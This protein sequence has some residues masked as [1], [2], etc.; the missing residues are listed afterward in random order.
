MYPTNA[1]LAAMALATAGCGQPKSN[2]GQPLARIGDQTITWTDLNKAYKDLNKDADVDLDAQL[3]QLELQHQAQVYQ[4]KRQAL[5]GLIQKRV[6]DAKAK[7]AGMGSGDELMQK[8]QQE[9]AAKIPD[10]PDAELQAVYDQAKA[11]GQQL[12]PFDQV[13]PDIIRFVKQQKMRGELVA[14]YEGIKKEQ[15]VQMLLLPPKIAVEATG[16]AK[17]RKDAPVTIVE[18][19]DFQCP[20]CIQAE[21][22]VGE[23]LKAYPDKIRLVYRDY[24]LPMH[25]LAPKAAEASHCA[26]A[27]GKYWDLHDKMFDA[28]GKLEVADLKKYARDVGLDGDKFDKCLDS[29]EMKKVVDA[30]HAAGE[31]IGISGTPAFFVNGRF[32]NG[33]Q[34]IEEFKTLVEADLGRV[35]SK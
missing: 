22:T 20:Y 4:A 12:P 6:L 35:A 14:Y 11:A 15:K 17:G 9:I 23:L 13:K 26:D 24:P 30:N 16:P 1:L 7:Q 2:P 10:P 28:Q 34:P 25:P 5:E 27:Q 32:L 8:Q 29:G 19:S 21:K 31:K 3:A 33:A 18:F